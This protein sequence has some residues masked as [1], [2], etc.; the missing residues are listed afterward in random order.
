MKF[1]N[2]WN[3]IKSRGTQR[4]FLADHWDITQVSIEQLP[5]EALRYRVHGNNDIDSFLTVGKACCQNI[6]EVLQ[7]AGRTLDSFHDVLDFG[8]GCGR[9]LMCFPERPQS[10]RFYGTDIDAEAIAWCKDNLKFA[11]FGSNDALPPL[12]YPSNKFDLIYAIS[13]FTHLNEEFQFQWLNELKRVTRRGGIVLITLHGQHIINTLPP[14]IVAHINAVG[15]LF[16][17][18]D[19]W[20][21]IFPEWYQT[22][23][24]TQKYVLEKFSQYFKVLDYI[25]RGLFDH[26]D[27]VLLQKA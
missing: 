14:D 25:P 9:T 15:F 4:E 1:T 7:R 2:I 10:V 12:A 22:S 19:G 20:K 23:F 26:H 8:C 21:G 6:T 18:S 3:S 27:I 17:V 11:N 5:P 16:T 24:H 13:V